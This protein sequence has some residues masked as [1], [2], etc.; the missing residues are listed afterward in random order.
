[1]PND[2]I[3]ETGSPPAL[4]AAAMAR[5]GMA[6]P[7]TRL[8]VAVSG[9]ADSV[10][11]LVSLALLAPGRGWHLTVLHMNHGLRG[12][13]ADADAAFVK[14]VAQRLDLP[15]V[16][17]ARPVEPGSNWENRARRARLDFFAHQMRALPLDRIATGHT[18]D[19]QAETVLMRILRGAA[20]ESLSGIRPVTPDGLIRP[21]LDVA[22]QAACE[23]LRE[24]GIGWRE[25]LTNSN[26]DYRRNWI[27]HEVLPLIE[28]R[29]PAARSTLARH[30]AAAGDDA[31]FWA[32]AA[33][34]A[35]A[36]F[37][38]RPDSM[39]ASVEPLAALPAALR[40]RVL[41]AALSHWSSSMVDSSHVEAVDGLI[42][43]GRRAGRVAL[44]EV[45]ARL[46]MGLLRIGPPVK[47][48]EVEPQVVSGPGVYWM[49]WRGGRLRIARFELGTGVLRAWRPGDHAAWT[50]S[51][52][53]LKEIFQRARV[54]GW[55]RAGWPVIDSGGL[56]VWAGRLGSI[57]G[58]EAEEEP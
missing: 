39:V 17:E 7:G 28:R 22:H 49:P 42:T 35:S 13:D 46:S 37:E 10:C 26:S 31:R 8:G 33:S 45:E 27:R 12:V 3:H 56:I 34:E 36:V 30:A 20:P 47:T 24:Q 1:M 23:W 4:I 25:D 15:S 43:P 54:A 5:H 58:I 32:V 57:A 40:R 29:Y 16:I 48:P 11:L 53:R 19:D 14:S 50:A 51:P 6:G 52:R 18:L 21:M 44:S 55:Q 9:G 38:Q 41:R 2:P